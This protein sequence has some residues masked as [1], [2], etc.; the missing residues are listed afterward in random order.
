MADEALAKRAPAELAEGAGCE[1]EEALRIASGTTVQGLARHQWLLLLAS[2]L[3][4]LTVMSAVL[5]PSLVLSEIAFALGLDMHADTVLLSLL[6][7]AMYGGWLVGAFFWGGIADTHGRRFTLI[8]TL[9]VLVAGGLGTAACRTPAHF[10]AARFIS[11]FAVGGAESVCFIVLAEYSPLATRS[12]GNLLFQCGGAVGVAYLGLCGWALLGELDKYIAVSPQR[13]VTTGAL[14]AT[15]CNSN[16]AS[17]MYG[18]GADTPAKDELSPASGG[19]GLSF[20]VLGEPGEIVRVAIL[21]PGGGVGRGSLGDRTRAQNGT[22]IELLVR[23]G[24]AQHVLAGLGAA[25]VECGP[26]S[27]CRQV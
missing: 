10:A 3:L 5:L 2:L 25:R 20:G 15:G 12:W 6:G 11:G 1:L 13:F 27:V 18:S 23:V 19:P 8:A 17:D 26:G 24:S 7:S 9:A 4:N 22:V 16:N 21:A 14:D